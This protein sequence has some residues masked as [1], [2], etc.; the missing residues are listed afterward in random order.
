MRHAKAVL[1]RL[2]AEAALLAAALLVAGAALLAPAP[3]RADSPQEATA[4]RVVVLTNGRRMV[5]ERAWQEGNRYRLELPQG[6]SLSVPASLVRRVSVNAA[7]LPGGRTDVVAQSSPGGAAP[8]AEAPAASRAL[9]AQDVQAQQALRADRLQ[10]TVAPK[11]GTSISAVGSVGALAA[12]ATVNDPRVM[13]GPASA[14][15]TRVT[16]GAGSEL[17]RLPGRGDLTPRRGSMQRLLGRVPRSSTA[18]RPA[19][20]AGQE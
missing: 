9:S 14:A 18:R 16:G 5:V 1:P 20:P 7:D 13:P 8:A 19:R 10:A 15:G 4:R 12:P 11:A 17:S 2:T 3:A 6:G